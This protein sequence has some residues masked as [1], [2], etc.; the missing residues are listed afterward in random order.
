MELEEDEL[1]MLLTAAL[2]SGQRVGAVG[3]HTSL[4]LARRGFIIVERGT[5]R[6]L[7]IDELEYIVARENGNVQ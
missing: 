5:Q 2:Q 3:G 1:V 4:V 6:E 7:S